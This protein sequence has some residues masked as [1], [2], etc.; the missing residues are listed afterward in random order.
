[1][2]LYNSASEVCALYK[3]IIENLPNDLA[4]PDYYVDQG[5]KM[6][7][8][9]LYYEET[10]QQVIQKEKRVKFRASFDYQNLSIGIVSRLRFVL[11][12]YDLEGN[13]YGF[14]DLDD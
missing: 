8:P 6:R 7:M 5:Y 9:W 2:Q 11:A 1:M 3:N 10:A 4:Y 14:E 12:K 13:F